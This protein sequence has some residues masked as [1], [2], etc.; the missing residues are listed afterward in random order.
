MTDK[1]MKAVEAACEL[2]K[3]GKTWQ[4]VSDILAAS[5][6]TNRSGKA[7]TQGG[8]HTLVSLKY[9]GVAHRQASVEILRGRQTAVEGSAATSN[10]AT[11]V[12]KDVAKKEEAV[13]ELGKRILELPNVDKSTKL[14]MIGLA[15]DL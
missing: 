11:I 6:F 12:Q 7:Y 2:R 5:G 14:A 4:E 8:I 10:S 9:P 13:I 15:L 3:Q 1:Q